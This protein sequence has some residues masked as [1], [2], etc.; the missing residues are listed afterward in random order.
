MPVFSNFRMYLLQS[1]QSI[2]KLFIIPCDFYA[3][4]VVHLKYGSSLLGRR[5]KS[6]KPIWQKSRAFSSRIEVTETQKP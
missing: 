2:Y 1:V 6:D 4:I 5:L 3:T